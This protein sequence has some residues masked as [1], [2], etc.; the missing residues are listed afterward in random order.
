M[1]R[2]ELMKQVWD[3]IVEEYLVGEAYKANIQ[4]IGIGMRFDK[5]VANKS[6]KYAI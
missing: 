4:A 3:L 5:T 1:G 6:R 2:K